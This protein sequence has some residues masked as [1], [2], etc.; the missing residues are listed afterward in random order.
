L[1][2]AHLGGLERLNRQKFLR[3]KSVVWDYREYSNVMLEYSQQCCYRA[4]A[5]LTLPYTIHQCIFCCILLG[6]LVCTCVVYFLCVF[7]LHILIRYIILPQQKQ[8][9]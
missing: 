2:L 6:I 8:M 1:A 3:G 9:Q 4:F 5:V 7:L